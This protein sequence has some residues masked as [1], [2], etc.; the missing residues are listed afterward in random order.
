MINP[1]S[2]KA[3]ALA[4][5]L[6]ALHD[7]TA[8]A[9]NFGPQPGTSCASSPASIFELSMGPNGTGVTDAMFCNSGTWAS[10]M[11]LN[12]GG[13]VG[14][15]T[16]SPQ[17]LFQVYGGE[18]QIGSSG[19][20]C[21]SGNAGALRYASGAITFCNGSSW[22]GPS[23]AAGGSNTQVQFNSS[24]ALAGSSNFVWDNTNGRVGIGTSTAGF[25]LE[26]VGVAAATTLYGRT[27]TQNANDTLYLGVSGQNFFIDRPGPSGGQI[28]LGYNTPKL[29]GPNNVFSVF[30]N[31]TDHFGVFI[32]QSKGAS[33]GNDG[34]GIGGVASVN[35]ALEVNAAA[36]WQMRLGYGAASA[37]YTYDIGRNGATGFL[38][39]YGN[40]TGANGYVFGGVDRTMMTIL[41]NGNVGIG[42]TAPAVAL[43]VGP[44]VVTSIANGGGG[45]YNPQIYNVQ[46][47]AV[48]GLGAYINDGTNNRRTSLFVNQTNAVWGLS[49]SYSSGD[50]PFVI[51]DA[52][53]ERLRIDTSGNVGIGITSPLV[54]LHVKNDS[55]LRVEESNASYARSI[56]IVPANNAGGLPSIA[57][58]SSAAF[59]ISNSSTAVTLY[60][61]NVGIGVAS[62]TSLLH[63]VDTAAKT[64]AYTGVLHSVTD[65]SS[66]ASIN[67]IGMDVESTG[68]WNGTSAINTGLVVNATGGTTNYA[69][70][71]SGGNVGIGT[72]VP[73][74][75]LDINGAAR[76]VGAPIYMSS[77][78]GI[79]WGTGSIAGYDGGSTPTRYLAFSTNS[80]ERLRIDGAG[81]VGI[82][83]T[84]PS[85]QLHLYL[86]SNASPSDGSVTGIHA[87]NVNAGS[88]AAAGFVARNSGL[89]TGFFQVNS[90]AN[91][92][93]AGVNSVNLGNVHGYPLGFVT[94]SVLRM[95][96][97]ATGNV[98][99]GTSSP[100][101]YA[102][103]RI[104]DIRGASAG[105]GAIVSVADGTSG[106]GNARGWLY[107]DGAS[108][109]LR[110]VDVYPLAFYASNAEY[111]RITASGNV[112]IGTTTPQ[113]TLDVNGYSKLKI[114]ASAPAT[115]NA[116]QEGSIAYTGTT[117]HYLCFCDGT[118]WEQA[119]TPASACVW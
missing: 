36:D 52:G 30:D 18:V 2:R 119:S 74:Y 47:S 82:G 7:T 70:T 1:I 20:S 80:A 99:I 108:V 103:L 88:G 114:N 112:G 60:N 85:S 55:G 37:T 95:I 101:N 97:N 90:G 10:V 115:C 107:T 25:P 117:T 65:T 56:T 6:I 57:S 48:A 40:Q 92:T 49:M 94:T 67:K 102:G 53:T 83:T 77:G 3:L 84:V 73:A 27:T 68:T 64:A 21:S 96:I 118:A 75:T 81:N 5:F 33:S 11:N 106:N 41:N 24:G 66:T 69:A 91:T 42:T 111:M 109:Q 54:G 16:T 34:V 113:A 38:N 116:G 100:A 61:G 58:N 17:S 19:A 23:A 39:F 9:T 29:S 79:A 87:Q 51:N 8:V 86:N 72:T 22:S 4:V 45:T 105:S 71:F 98:G 12:S 50:I 46:T 14:I 32:V 63:T 59:T 43:Q 104:V 13:Q 110:S 15:G 76:I 35:R 89:Y 31:A 44:G 78:Y 62:P 28:A 26:V 93:Y